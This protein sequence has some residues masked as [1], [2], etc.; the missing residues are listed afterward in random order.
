MTLYR[1]VVSSP[2]GP[3]TLVS[4]GDALIALLF[5]DHQDWLTRHLRQHYGDHEVVATRNPGG[6]S[7]KIAAY[8]EGSL[9]VIDDMHVR[10][11][12][13]DFQQAVWAALRDIPCGTTTT[14]GALAQKLGK[15]PGASRAVGLANGSNPVSIVVPCHRVI[16]SDNK[17]TGYGGGLPRKQWLL[18]HERV[19]LP[20]FARAGAE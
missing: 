17:L 11:A 3:V 2:I 4:D 19:E 1:D 13:T 14:Y 20:L 12:G 15:P 16:G 18:Q 6:A 8:F 5:E 10:L 7:Q 9:D